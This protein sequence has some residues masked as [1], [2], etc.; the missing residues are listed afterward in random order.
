MQPQQQQGVEDDPADYFLRFR[1]MG[2]C[3][4]PRRD[5]FGHIITTRK[6]PVD[7]S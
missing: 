4:A 5:K 3:G 1:E 6:Q 2:G 7:V